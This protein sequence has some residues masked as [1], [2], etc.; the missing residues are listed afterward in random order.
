MKIL[1]KIA[2]FFT[3][4]A[5]HYKSLG[6]QPRGMAFIFDAK[7]ELVFDENATAFNE[8][9][10]S[11][12][13]DELLVFI[14]TQEIPL[15]VSRHLVEKIV[16]QSA[17]MR[18]LMKNKF[19]FELFIQKY[20][21]FTQFK[22]QEIAQ[23]YYDQLLLRA[24]LLKKTELSFKNT[25]STT[26][27]DHLIKNLNAQPS[28]FIYNKLVTHK[29]KKHFDNYAIAYSSYFN[30]E[31]W[32]VR[33]I[34]KDLYLLVPHAYLTKIKETFDTQEEDT[35][36]SRELMLGLQ[37]DHLL[38]LSPEELIKRSLALH[39]PSERISNFIA[40]IPEK[41]FVPASYYTNAS[42]KPLW[43]LYLSGHGCS[44][45]IDL[46]QEDALLESGRVIGSSYTKFQKFLYKL[47]DVASISSV[48][49]SSCHM[50]GAN[51]MLITKNLN[52]SYTLIIPGLH[53]GRFIYPSLPSPIPPDI[54]TDYVEVKNQNVLVKNHTVQNLQFLKWLTS[55][56]TNYDVLFYYFCLPSKNSLTYPNNTLIIK[57]P[58]D[59]QFKPYVNDNWIKHITNNQEVAL[60]SSANKI[61]LI[62]ETPSITRLILKTPKAPYIIPFGADYYPYRYLQKIDAPTILCQKFIASLAKIEPTHHMTYEFQTAR[63]DNNCLLKHCIFIHSANPEAIGLEKNTD[64]KKISALL[65]QNNGSYA[66][67][68]WKTQNSSSENIADS[69]ICY[70]KLNEREYLNLQKTFLQKISEKRDIVLK[71]LKTRSSDSSEPIAK[72]PKY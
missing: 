37:I 22:N 21:H 25:L 53:Q 56:S 62:L 65:Y 42:Q 8:N 38:P 28:L 48:V 31:E 17:I 5:I 57:K 19:S 44:P 36:T 61:I 39:T 50:S 51:S 71:T 1:I 13:V 23:E 24:L 55:L 54:C 70:T 45:D 63:F 14:S 46:E 60:T 6:S 64:N 47:Q 58:N 3:L 43:N 9:T 69:I 40:T 68:Q 49:I 15:V 34:T 66:L 2:V 32:V 29:Q 33:Q 30:P 35:Y 7:K 72:R 59:N 20:G 27:Q 26:F 11:A 16:L 41:I 10:Y 67:S 12:L 18:D 4:C 52:L